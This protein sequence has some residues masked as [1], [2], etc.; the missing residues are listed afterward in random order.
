MLVIRI[1]CGCCGRIF[2]VCRK[3]YRGQIY[4]CKECRKA[5]Y[6]EIHREAQRRYR[7]TGRGKEKHQKAER[8]RRM[9]RKGCGLAQILYRTC[10]C[11]SMLI[12]SM[13]SKGED[14]ASEK[15]GCC[16]F[17]GASGLIVDVFPRRGY[18]R[19]RYKE[20]IVNKIKILGLDTG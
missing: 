15:T 12:R 7:Q 11:I 13:F 14:D 2:Y 5:G 20:N 19:S 4:C 9:K 1:Y 6:R 16:D 10:M 3:C 8:K 17:C 18:G